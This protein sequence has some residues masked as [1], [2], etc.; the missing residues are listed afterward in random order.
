VRASE[1]ATVPQL[2]E[3]DLPVEAPCPAWLGRACCWVAPQGRHCG[4]WR[5]IARVLAN[6]L[7]LLRDAIDAADTFWR[8]CERADR[9]HALRKPK[10]APKPAGAPEVTLAAIIY[11]WRARGR[12]AFAEP[13]NRARLAELSPAQRTELRQRMQQFKRAGYDSSDPLAG[14][15]LRARGRAIFRMFGK[16]V[17][18]LTEAQLRAVWDARSTW[19][20]A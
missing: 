17:E 11:A 19:F 13:A 10:P 15:R 8:A 20:E 7:E 4:C 16:P 6:E 1:L 3:F 9:E 5:C 14:E 12:A 2:A 18:D